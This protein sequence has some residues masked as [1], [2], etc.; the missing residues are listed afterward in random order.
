MTLVCTKL[1]HDSK[2]VKALFDKIDS[3][4]KDFFPND[5]I[6]P[7]FSAGVKINIE[8]IETDEITII[9]KRSEYGY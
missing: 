6:K 4:D 3:K 7:G 9:N 5:D 1:N 8:N 2:K